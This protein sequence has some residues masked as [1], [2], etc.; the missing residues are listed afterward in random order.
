MSV[1]SLSLSDLCVKFFFFKQ[2]NIIG[3]YKSFGDEIVKLSEIAEFKFGHKLVT[4]SV[5]EKK[6]RGITEMK[7]FI[8]RTKSS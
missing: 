8:G 4:C 2:K 6:M 1:K 5:L 3:K 7:D